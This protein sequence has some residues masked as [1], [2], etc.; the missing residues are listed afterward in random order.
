MLNDL[1]QKKKSNT[2]ADYITKKD[3]KQVIDR[4][5]S[6]VNKESVSPM[7]SKIIKEVIKQ[8]QPTD[9]QIKSLIKPLIP[10]PLKGEPGKDAKNPTFDGE[11]LIPLLREHRGSKGLYIDNIKGLKKHLNNIQINH[12]SLGLLNDQVYTQGKEVE[13]IREHVAKVVAAVPKNGIRTLKALSD[14]QVDSVTND[15]VLSYDSS[16]EMWVPRDD[17]R[18]TDVQFDNTTRE[19]TISVNEDPQNDFVVNISGGG[20]GTVQGTYGTY[21]IRATNEG[22]VAGNAR[23]DWSVDLQTWRGDA[24]HVASGAISALIGGRFNKA[25]NIASA[26][27]GGGLNDASGGS[28]VIIGGSN[29]RTSDDATVVLGGIGN[30]AAHQSS[31]VLGNFAQSELNDLFVVGYGSGT[32][33]PAN[34][35]FTVKK[36]GTVTIN[37]SYTLPTTDGTAGQVITTNGSGVAT[38]QNSGGGSTL[39]T[40]ADSS[41]TVTPIS[42]GF[43]LSV[44]PDTNTYAVSGSVSGNDLT[45]TMNDTTSFDI[46][47]S[48]LNSG[49]TYTASEG[50]SLNGSNF[51]LGYDTLAAAKANEVLNNR[52]IHFSKLPFGGAGSSL[53]LTNGLLS[54]TV[55]AV[56]NSINLFGDN[57]VLSDSINIFGY[58]NS[59]SNKSVS[60]NGYNHTVSGGINSMAI[61]GDGITFNPATSSTNNHALSLGASNSVFNQYGTMIGGSDNELNHAGST[62]VGSGL[63]TSSNGQ[64]IFGI[65]NDGSNTDAKLIIGNGGSDTSRSNSLEVETAGDIILPKYVET[66]DD[67]LVHEP[68]NFLYTD[69]DGRVLSSPKSTQTITSTIEIDGGNTSDFFAPGG[70]VAGSLGGPVTSFGAQGY[71]GDGFITG[72]TFSNQDIVTS[73]FNFDIFKNGVLIPSTTLTISASTSAGSF[74]NVVFSSPIPVTKF[75]KISIRAQSN[76]QYVYGDIWMFVR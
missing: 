60:I 36:D 4:I 1:L 74:T 8:A 49:S 9:D 55:T 57:N 63:E 69:T 67:T 53:V 66:R 5:M 37:N 17:Y 58:G 3:F 20:G 73:A 28:S 46:D 45:I 35:K 70:N 24:T 42:G 61:G 68:T 15:Q 18:V 7:S 6:L 56:Q 39:I 10:K 33:S 29:S 2:S 47:V 43:D 65:F 16:T 54:P 31:V 59:L 50:V 30:I 75:D 48:A 51:E 44:S 40:S 27:I 22:A 25:T 12:K 26:V 11:K 64:I 52:N 21:D 13:A 19:L 41:V 32:A 62:I 34:S 14:T 76:F 23:G 38:W 72:L 71:I